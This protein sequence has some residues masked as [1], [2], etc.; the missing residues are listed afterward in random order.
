MVTHPIFIHIPD[1][2]CSSFTS[3]EKECCMR[4]SRIPVAEKNHLGSLKGTLT[5]TPTYTHTHD[6]K[7]RSHDVHAILSASALSTLTPSQD[8]RSLIF[9]H[10]KR[11]IL[12]RRWNQH[13]RLSSH[14]QRLRKRMHQ[15]K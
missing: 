11:L 6:L 10:K 8:C 5:S 12:T 15:R 13:Q 1:L 14:S 3:C 9:I 4:V 7:T 2:R